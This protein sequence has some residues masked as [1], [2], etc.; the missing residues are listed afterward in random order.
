MA[1]ASHSPA[2]YSPCV[3]AL[4]SPG[5]LGALGQG[6]S[7]PSPSARPR[8]H[9]P[10]P[11]ICAKSTCVVSIRGTSMSFLL[12]LALITPGAQPP[13]CAHVPGMS[14]CWLGG[15]DCAF[16]CSLTLLPGFNPSPGTCFARKGYALFLFKTL[17]ARIYHPSLCRP[18]GAWIPPRAHGRGKEP[19]L[20]GRLVQGC[21]SQPASAAAICTNPKAELPSYPFSVPLSLASQHKHC[22]SPPAQPSAPQL[23]MGLCPSPSKPRALQPTKTG[24]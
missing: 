5:G 16:L 19:G 17:Q 4:P 10:V 7:S 8:S 24:A 9:K 1:L 21:G 23:C 3:P 20:L 2:C 6:C 14:P 15:Q 22:Q 11:S 18:S 13:P 12:L